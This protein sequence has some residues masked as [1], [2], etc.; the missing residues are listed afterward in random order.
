MS[1]GHESVKACH[2][3]SNL[4]CIDCIDCIVRLLRSYS[5]IPTSNFPLSML[6]RQFGYD[7][8]SALFFLLLCL[9]ALLQYLRTTAVD[10]NSKKGRYCT[11]IP[12]VATLI[13]QMCKVISSVT[14]HDPH[15]KHPPYPQRNPNQEP[16]AKAPSTLPPLPPTNTIMTMPLQP[17]P[18]ST[19]CIL[20]RRPSA[21]PPHLSASQVPNRCHEFFPTRW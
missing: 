6:N 19:S 15:A 14:H 3:G 9:F 12:S 21:Y 17:G 4:L 7:L 2:V 13:A 10:Q 20:H 8:L 16:Y 18:I 11:M 1:Q 5:Y